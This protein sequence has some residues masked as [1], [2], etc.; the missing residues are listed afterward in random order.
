MN[1]IHIGHESQSFYF[2]PGPVR[3]L[4]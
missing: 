4:E 3:S 2:V 1:D